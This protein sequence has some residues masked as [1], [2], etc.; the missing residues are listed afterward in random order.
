M[1]LRIGDSVA[2]IAALRQPSP[3]QRPETVRPDTAQTGQDAPARENR[4]RENQGDTL[5]AGFGENTV[6]VPGAAIQTVGR[7]LERAREAVPTVEELQDQLRERQQELRN[8]QRQNIGGENGES[9][10]ANA[11]ETEEATP[12]RFRPEASP[13]VRG[14]QQEETTSPAAQQ[15]ASTGNGFLPPGATTTERL[16]LLI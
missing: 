14:F 12:V 1:G 2:A 3:P 11:A 8:S 10:V 6:S 15:A 16:D 13:Q 7:N 9:G 4:R 5:S